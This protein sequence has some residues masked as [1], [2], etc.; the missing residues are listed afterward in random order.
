MG[1][2]RF[3]FAVKHLL[4]WE[5]DGGRSLV[6]CDFGV[7]RSRTVIEAFHY[8]KMGYHFEDEYKG[9]TNHLIYNCEMG[10]LPPLPVVERELARLRDDY[11]LGDIAYWM[12][13]KA[14]GVI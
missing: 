12:N 14:D 10:H 7:N 6:C 4:F 3:L 13:L 1:F 5:K 2:Q 8:A 11:M 9:Y